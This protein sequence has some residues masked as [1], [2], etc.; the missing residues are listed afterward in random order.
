[1][2]LMIALVRLVAVLRSCVFHFNQ[3]INQLLG[4]GVKFAGIIDYCKV[5]H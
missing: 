5:F 2:T 1:M 4:Q 3:Q